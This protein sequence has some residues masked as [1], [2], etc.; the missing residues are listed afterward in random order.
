MGTIS[1]CNI[2]NQSIYICEDAQMYYEGEIL[3]D[4]DYEISTT[5]ILIYCHI[6]SGSPCIII[7]IHEN[8]QSVKKLR[9]GMLYMVQKKLGS[10]YNNNN[11]HH[12]RLDVVG[13][14]NLKGDCHAHCNHRTPC[15][16]TYRPITS[17]QSDNVMFISTLILSILRKLLTSA[18]MVSIP[19]TSFHMS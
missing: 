5:I 1:R 12:H 17:I 4:N 13:Y 3:R 18:H 6:G 19:S 11:N 8:L 16:I 7:S 15:V 2:H 9:S 10:M 14:Y